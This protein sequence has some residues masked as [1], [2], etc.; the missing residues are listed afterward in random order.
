MKTKDL[1]QWA[2]RYNSFT[3]FKYTFKNFKLF[4]HLNVLKNV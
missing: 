4:I 2:K 1:K 3:S